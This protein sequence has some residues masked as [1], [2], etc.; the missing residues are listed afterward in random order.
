[1][2]A[3]PTPNVGRRLAAVVAVALFMAS[4]LW[5]G[6]HVTS[7]TYG[8]AGSKPSCTAQRDGQVYWFSD[9]TTTACTAS[10][11]GSNVV[12]CGCDGLTNTWVGLGSGG[13]GGS[14]HDLLD[15][16]QNQ[17]TVAGT[18]VRGDLV[19]GNSTP[20][21][22]RLA[23]GSSG[24]VLKSDGTDAAWGNV[25]YSEVTGTPTI[26]T[27]YDYKLYNTT[28]NGTQTE[29]FTDGASAQLSMGNSRDWAFTCWVAARRTDS[30]GGNAGY[31]LD[32][33][34]YKDTTAGSTTIGS[35]VIKTVVSESN[36]AWDVVALADT[37]N[38]TLVVK[39][40]GEAAKTIDW[41]AVCHITEAS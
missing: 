27:S 30:T 11:G 40:T 36:A 25:A 14:P 1:M 6:F 39:V 23:L 35:S 32:G 10:S 16:S 37:T 13:G 20:K 22:A 33:L 28:T 19:V 7:I 24:K 3:T 9:G 17:D 12:I 38:G 5:G 41:T 29:L 34:I 2:I 15:G 26:P 4:G 31:K 8:T 18:V 21:W